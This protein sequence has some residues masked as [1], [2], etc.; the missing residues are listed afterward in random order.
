M[1]CICRALNWTACLSNAPSKPTVGGVIFCTAV[2][3]LKHFFLIDK[4]ALFKSHS[5]WVH[6]E[7]VVVFNSLFT[8]LYLHA[9]WLLMNCRKLKQTSKSQLFTKLTTGSHA[10]PPWL[11]FFVGNVWQGDEQ[12]KM[13]SQAHPK[14][15]KV[16]LLVQGQL[17]LLQSWAWADTVHSMFLSSW[18]GAR[19]SWGQQTA[20]GLCF[21]LMFFL[22]EARS[23]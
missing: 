8:F 3:C 21:W 2:T 9:I 10:G 20:E 11:S 6:S 5:K 16:L 13:F 23:S 17:G 19:W 18:H 14:M 22:D 4:F 1:G 12:E 15:E 7:I